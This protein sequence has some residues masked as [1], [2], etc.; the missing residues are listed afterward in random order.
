M[1]NKI[2]EELKAVPVTMILMALLYIAVVRLYKD[3]VSAEDFGSLREQISGVQYTL[4]L[5][6]LDSRKHQVETE[7]FGLNNHITEERGKGREVDNLYFRRVDELKN[8]GDV[9]NREIALVEQ[10]QHFNVH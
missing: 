1:L 10:S 4:R 3:H 5:D 9:L 7:L 6:H 8:E 2:Y